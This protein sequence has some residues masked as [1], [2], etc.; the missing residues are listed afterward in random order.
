MKH[1]NTVTRFQGSSDQL[2]EDIGDLYYD[3]LALHLHLLA[4]KMA[5]DSIADAARG[6]NKLAAELMACSGNLK[7]AALHI[8]SAWS[9]CEPFTDPIRKAAKP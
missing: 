7:Q 1:T 9:I 8:D 5:K 3:A 6:R 2:A 4:E